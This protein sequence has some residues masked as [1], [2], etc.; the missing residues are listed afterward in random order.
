V[1]DRRDDT[2][3]PFGFSSWGYPAY[4]ATGDLNGDGKPEIVQTHLFEAAVSVMRNTTIGGFDIS[5][6][7]KI[8]R[9]HRLPNGHL[10]L[11]CRSAPSRRV[12]IEASADPDR[13]NFDALATI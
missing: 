2:A 1:A 11:D 13:A 10:V 4:M 9:L 6:L 5:K 12:T 8:V 7:L 3:R